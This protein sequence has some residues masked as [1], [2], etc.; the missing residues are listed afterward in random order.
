M[1]PMCAQCGTRDSLAANNE[2]RGV[3]RTA[4]NVIFLAGAL[5]VMLLSIM[6]GIGGLTRDW[7]GA[8]IWAVLAA[9]FGA[10]LAY[11]RYDRIQCSECGGEWRY[12]VGEFQ[13]LYYSDGPT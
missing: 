4:L 9:F 10:R 12:R 13:R 7:F 5:G 8:A 11:L 1:I 6:E 3:G 2:H